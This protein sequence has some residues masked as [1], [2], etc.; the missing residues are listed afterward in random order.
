M[1]YSTSMG[2]TKLLYKTLAKELLRT[3]YSGDTGYI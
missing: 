3:A 2:K 1:L